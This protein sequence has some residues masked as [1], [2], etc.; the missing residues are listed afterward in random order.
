MASNAPGQRVRIIGS[1]ELHQKL[2][3]IMRELEENDARYVV[4]VHGKPK[5]VLIG[6]A[7]FLGLVQGKAEP[8][9]SVVCLQLSAMLGTAFDGDSLNP[10]RDPLNPTSESTA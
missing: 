5:A 8:S 1:R 6:A 7:S 9:E 2:T 3:T 4:T 10:D